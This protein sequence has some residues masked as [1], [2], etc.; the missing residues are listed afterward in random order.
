M[1]FMPESFMFTLVAA[2]IIAMV[3]NLVLSRLAAGEAM[4]NLLRLHMCVS[5]SLFVISAMAVA[6]LTLGPRPLAHFDTMSADV[7]PEAQWL[8]VTMTAS[9]AAVLCGMPGTLVAVQVTT[10]IVAAIAWSMKRW[11]VN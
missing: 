8:A 9:S 4:R 10:G 7:N 3:L 5:V 1:I 6:L 2:C 11:H